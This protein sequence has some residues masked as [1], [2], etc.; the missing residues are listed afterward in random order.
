MDLKLKSKR[1]WN[2]KENGM[3]KKNGFGN[4]IDFKMKMKSNLKWERN[5]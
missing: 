1:N 5:L 4:G 2:G 3:E